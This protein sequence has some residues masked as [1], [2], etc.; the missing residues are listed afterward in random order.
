[1]KGEQGSVRECVDA[2]LHK[3]FVSRLS[4]FPISWWRHFF[5]ATL[6]SQLDLSDPGHPDP[7]FPL[8]RIPDP[9]RHCNFSPS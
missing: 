7:Q 5:S 1:M 3:P 4:C 6:I 9:G 8:Q 2:L